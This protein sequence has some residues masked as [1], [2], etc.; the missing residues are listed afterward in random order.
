MLAGNWPY[1]TGE[2]HPTDDML[3]A[4]LQFCYGIGKERGDVPNRDATNTDLTANKQHQCGKTRESGLAHGTRY[5][6]E[7]LSTGMEGRG[8]VRPISLLMD[9]LQHPSVDAGLDVP[10]LLKWYPAEGDPEHRVIDHVVL[11]KG[12]PGGSWQVRFFFGF[13]SVAF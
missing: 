13:K 11:G 5:K 3:T 7:C 8:S 4:R 2:P 10:S 9:Q 12:Q 1:Y 6:L